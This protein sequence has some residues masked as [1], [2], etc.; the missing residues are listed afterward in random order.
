MKYAAGT[1]VSTDKSKAEIEKLLIDCG[2]DQFM[3]G[4][5]DG[6]AVLG[7]RMNGR[8][9]RFKLDM[10]K[11]EQFKYT[12][13]RKLPRTQEQIRTAWEQACRARWRALFLVVKAKFVAISE[14]ITTFEDEFLANIILP[15]NTTAGDW[16]KPQIQ[17]SYESGRMP[18]ML[19]G[20]GGTE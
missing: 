17:R 4:Y 18:L 11:M 6:S 2:A 16:I 15:D 8:M 9:I 10:P 20:I 12:E 19:P 3:Y 13:A 14:G 5:S 7:F 1:D